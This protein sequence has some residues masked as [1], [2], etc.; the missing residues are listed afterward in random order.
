[1]G[2]V[3][4]TTLPSVVSQRQNYLNEH[5]PVFRSSATFYA[6]SNNKINTIISCLD[7]FKHKNHLIVSYVYTLRRMDGSIAHR[8]I[9]DF[10]ESSVINFDISS[11]CQSF[12][13]SFEIEFFSNVDLKIPFSAVIGYYITSTTASAVHTYGRSLN[14]SMSKKLVIHLLSP[15]KLILLYA[16]ER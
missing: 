16:I 3:S 13:G 11:F 7:Y 5:G 14:R 8:S 9:G 10:K 6:V 2:P 12:E 15:V 4:M 1:M